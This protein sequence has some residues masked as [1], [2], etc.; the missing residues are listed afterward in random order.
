[1]AYVLNTLSQVHHNKIVQK[2]RHNH[3]LLDMVRNMLSNSSL[4]ISQQMHALKIAMCLLN[5]FPSKVVPKIPFELQIGRKPMLR[6]L[7]VWDCSI[8]LRIQNPHEQ[9]LDSRTTSG[10]FIS[11]PKNSKRYRIYCLSHS[12]KIVESK[13]ARLIKNDKASRRIQV[14]CCL[15]LSSFKVVTP[16]IEQLNNKRR[17]KK[18]SIN[19]RILEEPQEIALKIS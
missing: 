4:P 18:A 13:N 6:H 19:E 7:H 12:T 15:L 14:E 8:E 3:T 1:M 11:Y 10:F 2:K 17:I 5:K 9:K 16:F